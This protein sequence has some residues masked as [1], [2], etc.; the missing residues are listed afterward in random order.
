MPE[1]GSPSLPHLI[2]GTLIQSLAAGRYLYL[3]LNTGTGS[4]WVAAVAE[5]VAKEGRISCKPQMLME[6]FQSPTLKRTFDRL[7]F[8]ELLTTAADKDAMPT[9]HP[10]IIPMHG[11]HGSTTTPDAAEM[12]TDVARAEG[13]VT[14]AELVAQKEKLA[15]TEVLLRG[16]VT[17]YNANIMDANWL[18][19]KDASDKRD[20]T[21]TTK[22]EV[23]V[24]D[25]VLIR[26]RLERDVNLGYGYSYDL[27]IRNADVT[28]EK[29]PQP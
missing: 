10:P 23:K 16:K 7:Y 15:G 6:G 5:S 22:V 24:G 8:V 19:V 14:I 13:G 3:E 29:P 25:T 9:N 20:L 26:G 12:K 17:K 1:S 27:I 21:V 11:G 2:E 18:R 28:V 4:V